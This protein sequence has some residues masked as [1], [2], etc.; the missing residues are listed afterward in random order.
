MFPFHRAFLILAA[1]PIVQ[2][3]AAPKIEADKTAV[4]CGIVVEGK[5][6]E[7]NAS[8]TV[9][10]TGDA[11]LKIE[12]VRPGC[13]CTVVKFDTMVLPGK[14][15]VIQSTVHLTGFHPGSISKFI[16]VLSNAA[17]TGSLLLT[18]TA[19][20]IPAIELSEDYI[21]LVQQK[22]HALVL[23]CANK[24]LHITSVGMTVA[25]SSPTATLWQSNLPMPISYRWIPTDSTRM[26]GMRLFRLE[27]T[28]PAVKERLSGEFVISTDD[29]EKPVIRLN[30]AIEK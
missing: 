4:D 8:F 17:N 5:T 30:G 29:P 25:A 2:V 13:G 20:L 6:D 27:L 16:T 11:P 9:R 15:S 22:P 19:K 18:I 26:D 14:S 3:L 21:S 23:A 24:D 28:A 10:N 12:N 1:F 7:I